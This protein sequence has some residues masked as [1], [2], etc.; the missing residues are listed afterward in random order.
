MSIL[1]RPEFHDEEAALAYVEARLWPQGP[2]CP[3]CGVVNEATKLKGKS[4][5]PGTYKCRACR[6]PFTVK[7]GTIFESSHIELCKW[8][9]AMHL[10][11][12][13]KKGIS[14]HQLH[15]TLGITL[16]SAWFLSHR[17]R[18]AMRND[19]LF[20]FGSEGGA[21]WGNEA[22]LFRDIDDIPTVATPTLPKSEEWAGET[23]HFVRSVL[24]N[25]TPDPDATQGVTMMKMLEGIYESAQLGR[26]VEI[27]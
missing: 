15:R 17:I 27:K 16:K 18:E 13:S 8:L 3:K 19:A 20:T 7:V 24:N 4:T 10:L 9:Q 14:T 1:S 6:K 11:C 22:G 5:R 12:S 23:G 21:E 2:A 25:T 26:E